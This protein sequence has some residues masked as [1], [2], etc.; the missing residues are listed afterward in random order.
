MR[1]TFVFIFLSARVIAFAQEDSETIHHPNIVSIELGGGSNAFLGYGNP[2]NVG[3]Q[4]IITFKQQNVLAIGTRIGFSTY[5]TSIS[6]PAEI[7]RHYVFPIEI[8]AILGAGILKGDFGFGYTSVFG[9]QKINTGSAIVETDFYDFL[10]FRC[11]A[12]LHI[13]RIYFRIALTPAYVP[14]HNP[15]PRETL[16]YVPWKL[17]WGSLTLGFALW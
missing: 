1:W 7:N 2:L 10:T 8:S 4:R 3:Y 15:I 11:G 6:P 9:R 17:G 13:Y 14:K 16:R 12:S 5:R